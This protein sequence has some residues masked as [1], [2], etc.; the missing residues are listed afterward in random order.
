[1]KKSRYILAALPLAAIILELLPYGVVLKFAPGPNEYSYQ[2]YSYFHMLPF[3]YGVFSPM[4]TAVL[5]CVIMLLSVIYIFT[6]KKSVLKNLWTVSAVAAFISIV[7]FLSGFDRFSIV[8]I[9]ISAVLF[10][11]FILSFNLLKTQSK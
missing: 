9:L 4:I 3:G 8:G 6:N 2:T 1:M 7:P 5:S 11:E 10:A